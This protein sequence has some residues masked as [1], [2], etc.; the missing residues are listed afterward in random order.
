MKLP[1]RTKKTLKMALV[2]LGAMF[3][4]CLTSMCPANAQPM[5][6]GNV[7]GSSTTIRLFLIGNKTAGTLS[8]P[9]D[10]GITTNPDISAVCHYGQAYAVKWTLKKGTATVDTRAT[11]LHQTQ[12]QPAGT[13]TWNIDLDTLGEGYGEY[14]LTCVV[15]GSAKDT[16]TSTFRYLPI[17]AEESKKDH[18]GDPVL[19]LS[20]EGSINKVRYTLKKTGRSDVVVVDA[21]ESDVYTLPMSSYD[22]P[23]GAYT[24]TVEG[25]TSS[26]WL[27]NLYTTSI[28]YTKPAGSGIPNMDG[29]RSGSTAIGVAAAGAVIMGAGKT[30]RKRKKTN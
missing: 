9:V 1:S 25:G 3:L 4:G 21:G 27:G 23:T 11:V 5:N 17:K 19:V 15:E 10:D 6:Q 22:L 12:L 8:V 24:L 29:E 16:N 13:D 2:S 26:Q 14:E 28:S 18:N 20:R 30:A 7:T